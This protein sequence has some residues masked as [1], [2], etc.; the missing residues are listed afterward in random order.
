MK[1][2]VV[3]KDR[4]QPKRCNL[5]CMA[6]CPP[7]RTG[8]EVIWLGEEGKAAIS[9]ELCIACG[10]CIHKCP[11]DA[12]KIIGLPE[13]L[14]VDLVHQFGRNDFRIFRLPVPRAGQVTGLLGPNGVGKTTALNILSGQLVPNLGQYRAKG[15]WDR[16]LEAFAGTELHDFLEKLATK[17]LR[18]AIKPQYVD[19]LPQVHKGKVRALLEKV[20][21]QGR[22]DEVNG[23]LELHS[24]LDKELKHLSGGELQKTAIAATMLKE[25]DLYLIDEPSSFL[26]IHQ[27]LQVA[28]VL[29]DLARGKQVI[30][31]EHDLAILDFIADV[32]HLFYGDA[33]AYGVVTQ[34]RP[35]RTAINVYLGG[36]LKEE[37]IR[38]RNTE[39]RFEVRPPRK[40]WAGHS[41]L[42][43][44]ALEKRFEGF[45]LTVEGGTIRKGESIGVVGPNAT[46]KTTFVKLLAGEIKPTKGKVEGDWE[47]SYKPQYIRTEFEGTVQELLEKELKKVASSGYFQ[48]EVLKNLAVD[49]LLHQEV[50]TLSGGELQRVSIAI[51]LGREADLYLL[52]EPSAY[53]DSD[54][55]MQAAK[56]IRRVIEK[57]GKSGLIV[58]HD[59]YFVDMVSDSLMVFDGEAGASGHGRGPFPM[60]EGMN[61]FLQDVG[62]T[63]RRDT[64]THRPRINKP[65]SRLDREQKGQGEYFYEAVSA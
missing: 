21:E 4:C 61:A 5:E 46:G 6:Y 22:L 56:T 36:Y 60:R 7:Q 13:A 53:M 27:R 26:D 14:K 31:V 23:Q 16:V 57:A 20:D 51:A 17:T 8:S 30:V 64:D 43:F 11:F 35:V 34:A 1:V 12:I 49:D 28:R 59:V 38:F 25:A 39:I 65:D 41:L 42:R 32:V 52:D 48:G 62:V 10:I 37:N 55:R 45:R 18:T 19:K 47:L 58:D 9:E 15:K 54:Q 63:F 33:G 3:D 44:G 2:A 40:D 29:Q 24:F 50:T